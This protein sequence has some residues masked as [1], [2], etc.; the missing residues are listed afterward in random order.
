[1]LWRPIGVMALFVAVLHPVHGKFIL[2]YSDT[3]INPLEVIQ[4]YGLHGQTNIV[5]PE[6][7]KFSSN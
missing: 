3:T 7:N 5:F 4:L 2:I 6:K 1:M